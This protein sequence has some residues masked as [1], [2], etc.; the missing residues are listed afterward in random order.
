[1]EIV[2]TPR[3][4][5]PF[6]GMDPYLE[7]NWSDVHGRLVTY[8]AD[9][10]G[11]NLPDDLTT[12]IE[13]HVAVD[14]DDEGNGN[15]DGGIRAEAG[16]VV[17]NV[18]VLDTERDS[19][20]VATLAPPTALAPMKLTRANV[21]RRR[22]YIEVRDLDG[23]LITVIEFV[24]PANKR[25]RGARE[26]RRKRRRL[27]AAGVNVVEI[28]LTRGGVVGDWR[29]LYRFDLPAEAE[30]AKYRTLIFAAPH[31]AGRRPGVWL[32]PMPLN[33]PLPTVK[34]PL[35]PKDQPAELALQPLV[36]ATYHNGRYGR[37]INYKRPC[38]PPL[39]DISVQF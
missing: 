23:K 11:G 35:R 7:R 29:N 27:I 39:A 22:R 25:G 16:I 28:D 24:T 9:A 31:V 26:F 17:P 2:A 18:E 10:L 32:H 33:E 34:I 21:P 37:T 19:A 14:T 13:R 5:S 12:H 3:E 15:E 38:D 8:A 20:G 36:T 30:K 1:M 6:P 4:T